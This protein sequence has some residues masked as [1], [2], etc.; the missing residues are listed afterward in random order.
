MDQNIIRRQKIA[1]RNQLTIE[2]RTLFS[3]QIAAR[4]AGSALFQNAGTIMLYRAV[5]G[6]VSLA[7]LENVRDEIFLAGLDTAAVQTPGM[8]PKRFVY[9]YCVD[10]TEMLALQPLSAA[11][12]A[13]GRFGILEPQLN[14]SV[15]VAPEEIDLIIC[16]CT[17]FD[18]DCRRIGMGAGYYD[19][20]LSNCK[21]AAIVAAAFECQKT[22]RILSNPW[23]RR[24]DA[25]FTERAIYLYSIP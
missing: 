14:A 5:R 24:M 18:E 20:F 15:A 13:P 6:E 21:N 19:R 3:A 7:G 8:L 16:P 25:V 2:E 17:A 23:D 10:G 22:D 11:S 12:W 9:P 4:I 1:A